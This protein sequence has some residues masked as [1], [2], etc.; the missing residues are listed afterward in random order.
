MINLT[1]K[2]KKLQHPYQAFI[3]GNQYFTIVFIS[4][5]VYEFTSLVIFGYLIAL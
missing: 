1:N 3:S 2:S 4:I 5:T